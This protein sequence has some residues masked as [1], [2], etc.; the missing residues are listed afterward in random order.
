MLFR[1][2]FVYRKL[3]SET[4]IKTNLKLLNRKQ[5]KFESKVEMLDKE[6]ANFWEYVGDGRFWI[7]RRNPDFIN[8][9]N[10]M[11]LEVFGSYWHKPEDEQERITHYSKH[12]YDCL[13]VWDY[14]FKEWE[15]YLNC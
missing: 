7:G 15:N 4:M 3:M 2:D 10:K 1:S 6:L 8:K 12:G 14:E 11:I 13:V 9:K 5:N